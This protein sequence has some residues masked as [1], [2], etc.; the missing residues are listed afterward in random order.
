MYRVLSQP[1]DF[2][3]I[4]RSSLHTTADAADAAA[5]DA[6]RETI[7]FSWSEHGM[8]LVVM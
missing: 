3:L 1:L 7:S 5:A 2:R 4:P 6:C 8:P